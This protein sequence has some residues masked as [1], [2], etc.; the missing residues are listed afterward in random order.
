MAFKKDM[1]R[2]VQHVKDSIQSNEKN[3]LWQYLSLTTRAEPI[4]EKAGN[5][6]ERFQ[7]LSKQIEALR[8]EMRVGTDFKDTQIDRMSS[9]ELHVMYD[10]VGRVIDNPK[11]GLSI[12]HKRGKRYVHVGFLDKIPTLANQKEIIV[13][14]RQEG[15][16]VLLTDPDGKVLGTT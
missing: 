1:P 13:M 2:L 7:L 3:S 4:G 9:D 12:I 8:D 11:I 5:D 6:D 14:A 10:L 16:N 15:I